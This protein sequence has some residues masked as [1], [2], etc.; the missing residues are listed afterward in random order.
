MD[1]YCH[2]GRQT[3][4]LQQPPGPPA[5][6]VWFHSLPLHPVRSALTA[7]G[8]D[9]F[10]FQY[11]SIYPSNI[12]TPVNAYNATGKPS[13]M[14]Y[15][16]SANQDSYWSPQTSGTD[17]DYPTQVKRGQV[18]AADQQNI[19][20]AQASDSSFP[21]VGVDFWGLTDDNSEE[22]TNWG[23]ISNK[24]NAYDGRCAVIAQ[25]VDQ[26]GFPCGGEAAN[27]GDFLDAVTQSNSNIFQQLIL[28]QLQ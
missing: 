27:Y 5:L 10:V 25:S 8:V 26:W 15:G 6:A 18:Y 2:T 28:Q 11:D 23:L 1:R 12:S 7:A 21:V 13:L 17:A 22:H 9:A 19:F 4:P 20:S 16:L 24:D 14:W 3:H